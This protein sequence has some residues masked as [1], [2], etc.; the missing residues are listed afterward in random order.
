MFEY[1]DSLDR[2][3]T[4]FF[5]SFSTDFLDIIMI[6]TSNKFIWMP[7]YCI[8]II[9]LYKI[10]KN[11]ILINVVICISVVLLSDFITSSIMKPFFER[12]RPCNDFELKEIINI[13]SGCGGK[14]SFASS[15]ASTTF[16]L[17]TI[18]Y[19]IT[20]KEIN[21]LF[22]WSIAIGYSRIYLGVHFFFDIIIGFFVGFL[23][24]YILYRISRKIV[25]N[26][27]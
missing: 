25:F 7:L 2:E 9:L 8:L 15:H 26:E 12:L 18:I 22:F 23:T 14:Y 13:V 16:S 24:S 4:V 17:A 6:L 5:N 19:L 3:I 27:N 20:K 21:F 11:R 1:I 10:D